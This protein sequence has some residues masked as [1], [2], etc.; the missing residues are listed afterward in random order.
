M[1]SVVTSEGRK[2]KFSASLKFVE[3][4]LVAINMKVFINFT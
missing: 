1:P 3:Y 4:S 2:I